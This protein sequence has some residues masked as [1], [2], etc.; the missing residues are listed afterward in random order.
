MATT[1][2]RDCNLV[3]YTNPMSRGRIVRLVAVNGRCWLP[4]TFSAMP[5][6]PAKR[7]G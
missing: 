1:E 3:F 7:S 6:L 2:S 5:R 4:A